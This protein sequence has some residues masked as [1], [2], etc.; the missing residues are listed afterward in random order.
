MR[1]GLLEFWGLGVEH[2]ASARQ[3]LQPRHGGW[4]RKDMD[5]GPLFLFPRV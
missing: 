3:P 2:E 1:L 4:L 5:L